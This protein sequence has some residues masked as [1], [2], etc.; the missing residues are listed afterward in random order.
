MM[1]YFYTYCA[2]SE[3]V[4]INENQL[5]SWNCQN[6]FNCLAYYESGRIYKFVKIKSVLPFIIY[7]WMNTT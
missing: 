2:L 3:S 1:I 5:I 6:A 7:V 4:K